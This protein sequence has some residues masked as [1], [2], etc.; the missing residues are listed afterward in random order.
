D[1]TAPRLQSAFVLGLALLALFLPVRSAQQA[2]FAASF[3]VAL[4]TM[5]LWGGS[6]G[7]LVLRVP[8]LGPWTSIYVGQ[9]VLLA[10][11]APILAA[12]ALV[13]RATGRAIPI[14]LLVAG[15]PRPPGLPA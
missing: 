8:R 2:L 7:R 4:A 14:V 12:N 15:G 3:A 13:A 1:H 10:P 5:A 11:P 9:Y 6:L